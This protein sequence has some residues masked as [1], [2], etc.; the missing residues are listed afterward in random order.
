MSLGETELTL[1]WS[2]RYQTEFYLIQIPMMRTKPAVSNKL[3]RIMDQPRLNRS[4]NIMATRN[5][6]SASG[7]RILLRWNISRSFDLRHA[8]TKDARAGTRR[9]R[10]HHI[11]IFHPVRFCTRNIAPTRRNDKPMIQLFSFW[12]QLKRLLR[13]VS[14]GGVCPSSMMAPCIKFPSSQNCTL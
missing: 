3:T 12:R 1:V 6:P 2:Q 13:R 4:T 9:K 7:L 5:N 14:L 11:F 10:Y 8:V